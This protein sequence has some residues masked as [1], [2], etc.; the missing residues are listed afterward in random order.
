MSVISFLFFWSAISSAASSSSLLICIVGLIKSSLDFSLS[1]FISFVVNKAGVM[2][3][4]GGLGR[5]FF[6]F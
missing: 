3:G 6:V 4:G 5:V 1:V 2:K